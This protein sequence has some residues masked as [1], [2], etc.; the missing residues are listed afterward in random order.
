MVVRQKIKYKEYLNDGNK[1]RFN[2][3]IH[4]VTNLQ[5][6]DIRK[7]IRFYFKCC[8]FSFEFFIFE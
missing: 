8:Y 5:M 2:I 6:F 7:K 3:T 4:A 1:R